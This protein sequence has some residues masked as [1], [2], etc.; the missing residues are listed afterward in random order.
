MFQ[1]KII[2]KIKEQ[3]LLFIMILSNLNKIIDKLNLIIN[4]ELL[5]SKIKLVN[6]IELL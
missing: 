2:K 3:L 4:F 1:L 5:F 6:N